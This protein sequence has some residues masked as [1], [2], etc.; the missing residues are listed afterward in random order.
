MYL[1]VRTLPDIFFAVGA[2][3]RS[4]HDPTDCHRALL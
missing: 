3:A 4:L 2:L 1:A